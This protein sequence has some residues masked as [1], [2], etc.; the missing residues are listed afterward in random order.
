[1]LEH[2]RAN[3][4][5]LES[6]GP[7]DVMLTNFVVHVN[8]GSGPQQPSNSLPR[9]HSPA[10]GEGLRRSHSLQV[11]RI[12]RP[13]TIQGGSVRITTTTANANGHSRAVENQY[14]FV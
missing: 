10:V 4:I 3:P 8:S 9:S 13:A 14:A 6:G 12:T 5:P 11:N 7:S 1:M 2:F